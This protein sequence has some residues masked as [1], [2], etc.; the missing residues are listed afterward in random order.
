MSLKNTRAAFE[1]AVT[2]AVNDANPKVKMIYD[3]VPYVTPSKSVSYVVMSVNFGQSTVQMQGA[4]SDYYSGFVQ[5]SIYVPK[6]K[7][8]AALAR[9]GEVVIDGLT[10]VNASDYTDT[11]S[12]NPR[13]GEIV[14]P[15]GLENEDESHYLGVITCQFS[16]NA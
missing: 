10:S 9:I 12:C 2:D 16:A 13:A 11:Y 1:K 3:N 8:T 15:A 5:C 4:A 7:G 6:N 14:G